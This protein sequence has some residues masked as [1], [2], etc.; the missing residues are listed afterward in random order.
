[1]FIPALIWTFTAHGSSR[2]GFFVFPRKQLRIWAYPGTERPKN[3]HTTIVNLPKGSD[4]KLQGLK[5]LSPWQPVAE[6]FISPP[7]QWGVY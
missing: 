2:R 5:A 1:M 4:T 3:N 6:G 7:L